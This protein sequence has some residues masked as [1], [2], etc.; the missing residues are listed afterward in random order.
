MRERWVPLTIALFVLV[1]LLGNGGFRR[2]V[3][4]KLEL[5]RL[6]K[7]AELLRSEETELRRRVDARKLDDDEL[8]NSARTELGYLKPGEI[9]YRFPPPGKSKG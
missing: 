4:Q 1:L 9:E 7:R 8:E 5:H 3:R 6:H 2:A